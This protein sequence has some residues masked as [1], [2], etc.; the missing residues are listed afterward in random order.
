[1][2]RSSQRRRENKRIGGDR[3]RFWIV[4][5][6]SIT[7]TDM[8]ARAAASAGS[9]APRR[10]SSCLTTLVSLFLSSLTNRVSPKAFNTEDDLLSLHAQLA[11]RV[12]GGRSASRR[13]PLLSFS[14]P[15]SGNRI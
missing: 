10:Q 11:D 7:M 5:A 2:P 15:S 4:T 8:S 14:P 6:Y 9:R 12:G 13:H 1:M 3:R